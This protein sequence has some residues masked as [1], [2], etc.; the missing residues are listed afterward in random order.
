VAHFG[1]SQSARRTEQAMGTLDEGA[2]NR[3]VGLLEGHF[4][5]P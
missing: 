4:G 3:S 1:P 2:A 5:L